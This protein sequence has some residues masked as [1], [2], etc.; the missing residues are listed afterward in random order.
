[1]IVQQLRRQYRSQCVNSA[2]ANA[3][4]EQ[5]WQTALPREEAWDGSGQLDA[6]QQHTAAS[7]S[8]GDAYRDF[9]LDMVSQVG[10]PIGLD[11]MQTIQDEVMK[12]ERAKNSK[13]LPR[14]K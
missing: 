4:Q 5:Q 3:S 10:L 9:L 8:S 6:G 12:A 1:M 7:V 2:T 14:P 11:A 13:K